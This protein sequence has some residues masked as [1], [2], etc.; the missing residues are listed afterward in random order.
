VTEG[1]V[2]TPQE[3]LLQ[4]YVEHFNRHDIEGVMGCFDRDP[5]VVDVT[6]KRHEGRESVRR[7]YEWQFAMFPDGRCDLTA[8]SG[9]GATGRAESE[10]RGTSVKTGQVIRAVGAEVAAFSGGKIKELVD[11]HRVADP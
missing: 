5:V 7:L 4:R 2:S 3:H 6:G 10:F 11:F 8:V 1:F 9:S